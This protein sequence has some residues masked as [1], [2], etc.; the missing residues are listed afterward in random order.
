MNCKPPGP[1]I[2]EGFLEGMKKAGLS[3]LPKSP[4]APRRWGKPEEIARV[5]VFLASESSSYIVG[6]ARYVDGGPYRWKGGPEPKD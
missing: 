3:E 2:T 6:E 4:H 5:A 1:V